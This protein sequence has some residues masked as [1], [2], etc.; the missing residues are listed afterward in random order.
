MRIGID[1]SQ[2][3]YGTG[4]S[5]YTRD[6]VGALLKVDEKNRYILFGG[7]LRQREILEEF[8]KSKL[9][10]KCQGKVFPIPPTIADLLW[11]RLHILPIERLINKVDVFHS[12]DWA[13]PPLKKA[14]G[15]TTI[16]DLSFLRWPESVHPKVLEAQK[17]RLGWV[18]QEE[19]EIIAVSKSTKSEI[20]D[21]LKIPSEKIHVIYEGVSEDILNFNKPVANDSEIKKIKSA[22]KIIKPFIIT[23]GSQAPRKNIARVIKAFKIFNKENE[24]QLVIVGDYRPVERLTK[25]VVVTGFLPREQ[26]IGLFFQASMLAFPSVYEGFGLPI[27]EAMACGCPVVTS[28]ISSMPEVAGEAAVLVDPLS[29]EGIAEGIKKASENRVDLIKKGYEQI[30]KFSWEKCARETLEIYQKV[31]KK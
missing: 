22:F 31:L 16:H 13:Q 1:I 26:M 3:V 12:S 27:L 10:N 25:N 8:I 6:L 28:N 29:V 19:I 9:S 21:L 14:K 11:N 5:C 4:V 17:K 7:S 15:V 23:Y 18:K 20:V 30:K 24:F 2:I